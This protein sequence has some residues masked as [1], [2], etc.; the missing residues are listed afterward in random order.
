MIVPLS[1]LVHAPSKTGKTTL[2][3]T[4]PPPLLVL[5][6]EGRTR[7]LPHAQPVTAMYG[8]PVRL[9][10]W[11]PNGPPPR[12]D[13]TWDVCVVQCN[14]WITVEQTYGW[15]T[16]GQHDFVSLVMDSLTE[17]Q[18]RC[19]ENLKGSEA[20]RIQ[21]W[22]VLLD[23][24]TRVIRGLRDL[25]L[26]PTRPLAVVMFIAETRQSQSGKW[27]PNMQGQISTALP[28]WMDITG[29]LFKE[30]TL[31][32]NGQPTGPEVRKLRISQHPEYEAGE[33]VQGVLGSIIDNP[34]IY[35]MHMTLNQFF[36]PNTNGETT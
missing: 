3:G 29:Y 18:R 2:A 27:V 22:G 7:F 23:R 16:Q 12:Y 4:C 21:D 14:D 19:R 8:R 10:S 33:A 20:M 34:N 32:A 35:T 25:T 13:G 17:L 1:L 6:A 26:H 30:N 5:D 24:M 31:D 11:V 36:A 15:L 28:Y 9:V